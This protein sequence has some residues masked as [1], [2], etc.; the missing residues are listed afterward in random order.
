L[1]EEEL[2]Q[3]CSS[4]VNE[5]KEHSAKIV[6][7]HP[8]QADR[9]TLPPFHHYWKRVLG[10]SVQSWNIMSKAWNGE[11]NHHKGTTCTW[12]PQNYFSH[13]V[14]TLHIAFSKFLTNVTSMNGEGL[15]HIIFCQHMLCKHEKYQ[16]HI[17]TINTVLS[18][19][20]DNAEFKLVWNKI[21]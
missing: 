2:H 13:K 20:E 1:K 19:M 11:L 6:K 21:Q 5:H 17:P 8:D 3:V 10:V 18:P 9:F 7:T 12:F 14:I 15:L 16:L 4:L